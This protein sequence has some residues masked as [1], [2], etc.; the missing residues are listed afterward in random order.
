MFD[1]SKDFDTVDRGKLFQMLSNILDK[2]KLHI[3]KI[4]I[5]DVELQVKIGS[6]TGPPSTQT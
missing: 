3:M 4:L 5:K 1:V 6:N 2:D